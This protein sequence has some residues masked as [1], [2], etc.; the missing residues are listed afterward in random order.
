VASRAELLE[1]RGRMARLEHLVTG[2]GPSEALAAYPVCKFAGG[3][4]R[5]R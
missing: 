1:E 5:R 4:G 2:D 3:G